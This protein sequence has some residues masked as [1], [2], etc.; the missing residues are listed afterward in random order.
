MPWKEWSVMDERLRFVAR[1]L[2]GDLGGGEEPLG[3][4]DFGGELGVAHSARSRR[5]RSRNVRPTWS[6]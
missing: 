4:G 1:L 6:M 5:S 2:D 3:R